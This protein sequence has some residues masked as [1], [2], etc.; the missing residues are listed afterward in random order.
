MAKRVDKPQFAEK[1][2]DVEKRRL[3]QKKYQLDRY[4]RNKS[5]KEVATEGVMETQQ[6]VPI[7]SGTAP[8]NQFEGVLNALTDS[9]G[10]EDGVSKFIKK[11]QPFIPLATSF[12]Q[13]FVENMNAAR[14]AEAK[15]VNTG[16]VP[17]DGWLHVD[18]ISRL[19]RKYNPDGSLSQWYLAGEYYDQQA[20]MRSVG[21]GVQ[22]GQ[23]VQI[24]RTYHGEHEAALQRRQQQMI[25]HERS[26]SDLQREAQVFDKRET[27]P[28]PQK[29][30][31]DISG[32]QAKQIVQEIA[33]K[34]QEDAMKYLNLVVNYFKTRPLDDFEKDLKNVD[35]TIV[36]YKDVFDLLPFQAK[37]AFKR[38]STEEIE[39][40]IKESDPE[41]YKM[42]VKKK[43]KGKLAKLWEDLKAKL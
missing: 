43:L 40:M 22:S 1:Y 39:G 30:E 36:K 26:M 37:E 35:E 4:H 14:V 19:K 31:G 6:A 2:P 5:L 13:G 15:P 9:L 23:P 16:P 18:G 27:S 20:A 29:N 3:Y 34:L 32:D 17:P 8:T 42:I 24:E 33:P 12:I 25:Q 41:K 7:Q 11:V 38:I 21:A 28:E 10:P